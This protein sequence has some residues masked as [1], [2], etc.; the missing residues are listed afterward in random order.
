MKKQQALFQNILQY[1]YGIKI[2]ET[3]AFRETGSGVICEAAGKPCTE[4]EYVTKCFRAA[5]YALWDS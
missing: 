5:V 4:T 2:K 3:F 1:I